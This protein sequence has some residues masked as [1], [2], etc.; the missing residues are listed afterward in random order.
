ME[1][2]IKELIVNSSDNIHSLYGKLYIPK[3]EIK[4]L[5]HIV[6]G[7]TEHIERYADFMAEL[8]ENGY[9]AFGYDNLGHGRTAREDS[10]LGFISH[11]N[12]W[13]YLVRDVSAFENAVQKLFPDKP[14]YLFGHSMGSFIVRIA[15]ENKGENI[16]KLI[17]CGTGGKNPLAPFGLMLSNIQV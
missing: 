8:A 7:M 12:G 16:E 15:A 11:K 2:E 4:G 5:F 13:I 6:H 14:L 1:Y 10:E 17:I 9:V 3:G